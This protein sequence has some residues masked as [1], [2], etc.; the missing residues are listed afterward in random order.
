MKP[1]LLV[2]AGIRRGTTPEEALQE[3]AEL[4]WHTGRLG[5]ELYLV[6]EHHHTKGSVALKSWRRGLR[7]RSIQSKFEHAGYCCRSTA[8]I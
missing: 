6:A 5:Y 3:S 4:A 2:Q 1:S 7:L 8:L